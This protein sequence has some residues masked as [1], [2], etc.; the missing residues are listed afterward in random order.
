MKITTMTI[1]ISIFSFIQIIRIFLK[2]KDDKISIRSALVWV[3]IW[4]AIGLSSIFPSVM[5]YFMQAAQMLDR[6]IF[7]LLLSVFI[8]FALLFN[9]VSKIEKLQR[10]NAKIT[11]ELAILKFNLNYG[12]KNAKN[13]VHG[14][15]SHKH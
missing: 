15:N 6:M 1:I 2:M 12:Q 14:G 9:L 5:D 8:L 4:I 11:R 3:F 13:L 7:V 10:D